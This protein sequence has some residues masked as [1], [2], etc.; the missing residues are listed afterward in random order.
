MRCRAWW[1]RVV[2]L[3]RTLGNKYALSLV[4]EEIKPLFGEW[5]KAGLRENGGN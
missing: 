5:L 4:K 1:N 3:R 2:G